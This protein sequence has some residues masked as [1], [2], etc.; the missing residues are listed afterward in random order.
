[1][2]LNDWHMLVAW[3]DM[4]PSLSFTGTDLVS[5]EQILLVF[6]WVAAFG[7]GFIGGNK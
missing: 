6:S 5:T 2:F 1:M 7:L 3:S 4:I